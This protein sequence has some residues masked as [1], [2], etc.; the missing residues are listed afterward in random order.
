LF[1]SQ[2]VQFAL[3]WWLTKTT[4]SATVLATA[5]FIAMLPQ[6]ILG[7]VAGALVDRWD[8]RRVMIAADGAIALATL[9]LVVLFAAGQAEVW[10][11]YVIMLIRSAGGAFHWPAMQASTSLMVPESQLARVSGL[12]SA[13]NGGVNIIAPPL[14]ALLLELLPMQGVLAVDIV[15]AGVAISTLLIIPIPQPERSTE[16]GVQNVWGDLKAGLDYVRGWTGLMILLVM[17]TVINFLLVPAGSLLPLLVKD[18]FGG[19]A[20]EYSAMESFFA[21]GM[22]AGGFVLGLWGGFRRKIVTSQV[23]VIG[24]G[25]AHIVLGLA[26]DTLFV[27]ALGAVFMAGVMVAFN[28]VAYAVIQAVVAPDMQGRVFNLIRSVS[29]AMS[30]LS[31]A[32]AGPLSEAF[33]VRFWYVL[34]GVICTVMGSLALLI[35]S[36]VNLE[37][38]ARGEES[39]P[40]V[41]V[42]VA[43]DR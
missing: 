40:P 18:Y 16:S 34:A 43:A 26:P 2:L 35:P 37:D 25:L 5:T 3:V 6:I 15:T 17:A 31:L 19:Q 33:G 36:V 22:L 23:G 39:A 29:T 41:G 13:L 8:R 11:I 27:M 21:V 7:P 10:H 42:M 4:G 32:V 1:G 12:N 24:I 30:P 20:L 38:R 9:V 28:G 14:G